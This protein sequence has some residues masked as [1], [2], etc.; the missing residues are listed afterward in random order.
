MA[1]GGRSGGAGPLWFDIEP[2]GDVRQSSLCVADHGL[3]LASRSATLAAKASVSAAVFDFDFSVT[4]AAIGLAGGGIEC[5]HRVMRRP[6]AGDPG[7]VGEA[8]A[9]GPC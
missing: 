6:D 5:V 1:V 4:V 3:G 9:A 7:P 8:F 2:L